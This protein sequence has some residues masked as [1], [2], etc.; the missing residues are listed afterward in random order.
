MIP[1]KQIN[2]LRDELRHCKRPIFFFHDDPDGLCSFL[3]FYRYIKEG[4][5]VVIKTHPKISEMFIRKVEEYGADKVFVLDIAMVDQ[6]FIDNVH[7][8]VVWVDH[9]DPLE[10]DNVKYFNSRVY[11]ENEPPSSVCFKVVKQDIWI[12]MAGC[13]G[14]WFMPEFKNE[15]CKKYPDLMDSSVND[16]AEALFNTKLGNLVKILSFN[17][18]G[19]TQEV[20]KAAKVL[21]R[22]ES[23][24]EILDQTTPKGS[25]IYKK[26]QKIKEVYDSLLE[27]AVKKKKKD[28]ILLFSY[29][30]DKM[31]LTKELANEL[32]YNF[33][34]KIVIVAREKSG[35]MKCSIR[36][37][38]GKSLSDALAKALVGIEGYGGGHENACGAVIKKEDFKKFI[39]N[40][41]NEL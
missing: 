38:G 7:L 21:T 26:Y 24:Y 12:A 25:F 34:E 13:I 14:D 17:L 35:E 8:P 33:P 29:M 19:K 16:P 37:S 31:S 10:R 30:H 6:E 28:R 1:E 27:K 9:H 11:G 32:L 23:P 15:F 3:L 36:T 20:I 41:R 22:I 18:K 5:G 2:E 39:D 4:K 40:L